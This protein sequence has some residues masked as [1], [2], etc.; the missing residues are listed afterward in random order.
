VTAMT[1]RTPLVVGSLLFLAVSACSSPEP[2]VVD[3]GVEN[4]DLA[5]RLSAIPDGL[6]VAANQGTSLE[7]RP[8]GET[9]DGVI[10]F[11]VGPEQTGVNLVA[12]VSEHQA[13]IEGLPEGEYRG[14]QELLGDFGTAF[15]SRGRF[16]DDEAL[17][18]ETR[19]MLIHPAGNRL[20]TIAYRYPAAEDS[21]SR[22][23]QLIEVLSY[24]E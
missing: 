12:A 2:P 1:I 16:L 20:L 22:V 4:L 17:K 23:E 10:W 5:I 9:A 21:A 14:A 15:Y 18:E 6:V 3:T 13:H 11:V 8:V 19:I 24:L 7:L